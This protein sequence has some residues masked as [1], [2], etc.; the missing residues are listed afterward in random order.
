MVTDVIVIGGGVI[1]LSIARELLKLGAKVSVLERNH[2]GKEASWAG[3]GI[4]SPLLPWDY[5][6]AVTQLT[7]F[8][9]RMFPGLA[10]TLRQETGIDSEYRACGLLVLPDRNSEKS[11][12]FV[13]AKNWCMQNAFPLNRVSPKEI[14][15]RLALSEFTDKSAL[16]LSSVAQVR[17]PRFLQALKRSVELSGGSIFENTQVIGWRMGQSQVESVVTNKGEY[18]GADF[19]VATGAWSR[20]ILDKYALKV[21]IYPVRGQMLLFKVETGL[22]NTVV[23][24]KGFYLIPRQDGHILAGST[25]EDVGFDKSVTTEARNELLKKAHNFLP[26][27][28]EKTLVGHWSGLRPGSPENIPVISSHPTFDNL[29]LSSGHHRYGVTMAPGSAQLLSHM[30]IGSSQPFD[31]TPYQ[32]SAL[33]E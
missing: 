29:Y 19:V 18:S 2:C 11:T 32:W 25:T 7:Q 21:N 9:N 20:K 27:L 30:I 12:P 16:W 15:P 14:F 24:Q 28:N 22:L 13:G 10:E 8:S 17:S 6:D 5:P 26:A 1:G 3:G 4:L 33:K 31:V 23:L